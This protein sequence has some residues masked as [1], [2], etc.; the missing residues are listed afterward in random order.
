MLNKLKGVV[1]N[2]PL[3]NTTPQYFGAAKAA[4]W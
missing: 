1:A 4:L 3:A 2:L